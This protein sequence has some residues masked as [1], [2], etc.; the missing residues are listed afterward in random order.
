MG[1]EQAGQGGVWTR[2]YWECGPLLLDTQAM[3]A[4]VNDEDLR[5]DEQ[6]FD[7]LYLLVQ[8]EGR[9]LTQEEL[10]KAV[11]EPLDGADRRAAARAAMGNLSSKLAAARGAGVWID[12]LP[13][14]RFVLRRKA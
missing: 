4:T 5:L 9:H 13:E 2:R 12:A 7:A 11:W 3:R 8:R 6:E 10:Y 14:S 1:T